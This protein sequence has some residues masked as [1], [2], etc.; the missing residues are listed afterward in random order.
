MVE[1]VFVMEELIKAIRLLKNNKAGGPDRILAEMLKETPVNLLSIILKIMNKIKTTCHYPSSWGLGITSL[2]F[3][4]GDDEDPNSY[5]AITV[6]TVLSK[7]F[8]NL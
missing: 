1:P 7:V 3:K 5:R 8:E 6:T 4:E 2:L